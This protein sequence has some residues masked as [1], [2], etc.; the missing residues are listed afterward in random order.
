MIYI[1]IEGEPVAWKRPGQHRVSNFVIMYDRQKLEKDRIRSQIRSQYCHEPITQA[2]RVEILYYLKIPKSTSKI[3]RL[4]IKEGEIKHAKKPDIDNLTKFI[5]DCMTG[6]I[7]EDDAQIYEI[8]LRKEYS[9]FPH[10]SI[11]ISKYEPYDEENI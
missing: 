11:K 1:D 7:Y 3:K 10:T 9:E 6:H 5:L 8:Y 2:L 4:L